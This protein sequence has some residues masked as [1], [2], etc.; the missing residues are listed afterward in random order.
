M[1]SRSSGAAMQGVSPLCA[2]YTLRGWIRMHKKDYET[3]IADLNAAIWLRADI[4]GPV[5][6]AWSSL[7]RN[8]RL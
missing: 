2:A 1:T 8:A 5:S 7:D 3:A 6:L 4:G